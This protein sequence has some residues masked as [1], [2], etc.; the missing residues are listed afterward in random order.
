[1][2]Y[3]YQNG[4]VIQKKSSGKIVGVAFGLFIAIVLV[5]VLLFVFI[6]GGGKGGSSSAE[7][8]VENFINSFIN[9][10]TDGYIGAY[11][12]DAFYAYMGNDGYSED[13]IDQQIQE[14]EEGFELIT[15]LTENMKIKVVGHE[16]YDEDDYDYEY[17]EEMYDEIG[18]EIAGACEV[19]VEMEM[20]FMG[21]TQTE[22]DYIEAVKIGS[23]WYV[24]LDSGFN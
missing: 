17:Y 3:G 23:N 13:E 16:M 4:Q 19:E 2:Q 24:A 11:N 20:S 9:A 15:S 6:L 8:A 1:M 21:E 7:K 12:K 5:I 10:D 18:F 22:T 14:M